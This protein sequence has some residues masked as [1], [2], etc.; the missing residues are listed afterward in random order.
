M[1]YSSEGEIEALI[2]SFERCVLPRSQ[3]TQAAHLTVAL[4]YLTHHPKS[5]A[6]CLIREGIQ[7][8][9]AAMGIVQTKES[10]Y[11]ETITLF[12]IEIV[13]YFRVDHFL[14]KKSVNDS[15]L[16]QMN[17]L[18]QQ[19]DN[20]DFMFQYYSRD[21]LMS[22]EARTTWQNPDLKSIESWS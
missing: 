22:W 14:T 11:H 4:W 10:G 5:V 2:D 7:R 18:L 16:S 19:Y 8:Y 1:Y 6:I 13:A 9:N 12:W 20:P 17:M 3:W 21:R 15:I